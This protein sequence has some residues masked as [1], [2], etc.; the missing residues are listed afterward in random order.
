MNLTNYQYIQ[1]YIG[2]EL[3]EPLSKTYTDNINPATGEK[4][5]QI[6]N[7][8]HEDVEMAVKAAEKAFPET[9]RT[10]KNNSE[11]F[12]STP[13]KNFTQEYYTFV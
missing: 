13:L 5:G 9:D 2:G 7:S 11:Y 3:T 1:N 8:N 12:I 6:P 10:A 4:F